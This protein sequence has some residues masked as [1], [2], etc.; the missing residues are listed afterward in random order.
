MDRR[1]RREISKKL[2]SDENNKGGRERRVGGVG[3]KSGG[4]G[5]GGRLVDSKTEEGEESKF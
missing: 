1:G 4:G 5:R 2:M 3:R